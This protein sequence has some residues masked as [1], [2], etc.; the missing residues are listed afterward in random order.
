M[1][2][3]GIGGGNAQG[4]APLNLRIAGPLS[5]GSDLSQAAGYIARRQR[6]RPPRRWSRRHRQGRTWSFRC[7]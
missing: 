6:S 7:T 2:A 3:M 4:A 1:R 5:I